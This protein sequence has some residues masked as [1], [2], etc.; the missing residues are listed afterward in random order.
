MGP[1]DPLGVTFLPIAGMEA[2]PVYE[3]EGGTPVF[4]TDD[5]Y[6]LS[7]GLSLMAPL[8]VVDAG[9]PTWMDMEGQL[10]ASMPVTGLPP[11]EPLNAVTNNGIPVT[12]DGE[13]VING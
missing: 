10:M 5:P 12:N 3:A 11:P 7:D 2:V 4:I 9:G 13:T 8:Y 6:L 1:N